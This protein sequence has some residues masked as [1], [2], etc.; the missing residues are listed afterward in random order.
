MQLD[1]AKILK[2]QIKQI[3]S[4]VER[5]KFIASKPNIISIEGEVNAPGFYKYISSQIK[6][7]IE[8]AGGLNQMQTGLTFT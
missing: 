1:I 8:Q 2:D 6:D 5:M 3:L 7:V 4:F